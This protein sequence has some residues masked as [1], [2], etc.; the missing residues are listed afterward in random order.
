MKIV[1]TVAGRDR[2]GIVY[3]IAAVCKELNINIVDITQKVL[4]GTFSMVMLANANED[5]AKFQDIVD[6]FNKKGEEL[7]LNIHTM[8]EDIFNAMH[9]I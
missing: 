8:R 9:R 2:V 4:G 7:C 1:I 6:I 5:T 3:D